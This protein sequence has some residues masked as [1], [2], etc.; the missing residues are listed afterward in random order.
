MA[1]SLALGGAAVAGMRIPLRVA[2]GEP[3]RQLCQTE[4]RP[5]RTDRQGDRGVHRVFE[6]KLT[7]IARGFPEIGITAHDEST[8]ADGVSTV[9][10]NCAIRDTT[11]RLVGVR[12]AI[13]PDPVSFGILRPTLIESRM[14]CR[15]QVSENMGEFAPAYHHG[16][17]A[18]WSLGR[19]PPQKTRYIHNR[20]HRVY[21]I[22]QLTGVVSTSSFW[23]EITTSFEAVHT[24]VVLP[25]H[26]FD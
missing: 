2:L 15:A 7:V 19:V 24:H 18:T 13:P 1:D 9:L 17:A 26:E 20:R 12:M 22:P 16:N 6:G 5:P 21:V 25:P 4:V 10:L 14:P 23:S 11:H 8:P 3:R